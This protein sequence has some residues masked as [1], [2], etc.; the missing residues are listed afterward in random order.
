M[1]GAGAGDGRLELDSGVR[2]DFP[3]A[4]WPSLPYGVWVLIPHPMVMLKQNL[5]GWA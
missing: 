4:Q 3:C 5:D 1:V 2:W